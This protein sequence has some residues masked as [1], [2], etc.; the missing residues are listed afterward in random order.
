VVFDDD[1]DFRRCSN[2]RN[3]LL[4]RVGAALEFSVNPFSGSV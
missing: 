2:E 4:L 1:E 3:R